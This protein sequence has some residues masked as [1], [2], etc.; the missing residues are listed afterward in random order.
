M[1]HTFGSARDIRD[2]AKIVAEHAE[3][4]GRDA[5]QIRRS[6]NLSISEGWDEVRARADELRGAGISYL[7][8]SWPGEGQRRVDEFV[9]KIMPAL[10]D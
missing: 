8:V 3:R 7:V 6:T 2:Q 10:R 1:W 4:A 5:A 9:E